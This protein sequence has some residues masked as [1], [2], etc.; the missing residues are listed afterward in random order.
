MRFTVIGISDNA[1]PSFTDEVKAIIASGKVFSG[2]KRHHHIVK[3]LLPD[4]YEWIEV[5]V[6]LENVFVKYAGHNEVIVFASGDPLFFGYAGTLER[7]FPDS[8]I[9]VFP[10]FNSLQ[11]LAH[12]LL[13]PYQD[14]ICTSL[15][16]RPWRNLDR[17]LI[18]DESMI[19]VL[20]DRNMT[21][22][23]IAE[24]MLRYGFSNYRIAVG[25]NLGNEEKERVAVMS[26]DEAAATTFDMPNCV[27]LMRTEARERKLGL[28]ENEF[29]HL[30][31]RQK[32]ITKMPARLLSIALLD[33]SRRK[34][35]WDV[36]FCT[37]SVSIE[38]RRLYPE[39]VITAFEK[40]PEG[41]A[42]MLMNSEKFGAPDIVTVIGDFFD[43]DLAN[44]RRP[45]AVFIGGHGGRLQEMIMRIASVLEPGGVIVFNSVSDTSRQDFEDGVAQAGMRIS[46]CHTLALDNFN[47]LTIIKA[48]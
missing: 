30:D 39:L 19:G 42:L 9:R 24:R 28:P 38:A 26:L 32:M 46:E 16:G 37:G 6:P 14:M 17:R 20:T 29:H 25:E 21:P 40:R 18:C 41:E 45:D 10:T 48:E 2:G 43:L 23:A 3:E 35:L 36:G 33:L 27:I 22:T 34:S 8:E 44:Y 11:M 13:L 15:T 5:T 12:R 4:G 47:P 31:G 1:R 7:V